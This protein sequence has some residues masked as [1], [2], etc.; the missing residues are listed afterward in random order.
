[1]S[2]GYFPP[3]DRD[4]QIYV[5]HIDR[6]EIMNQFLLDLEAMSKNSDQKVRDVATI[7]GHR[8]DQPLVRGRESGVLG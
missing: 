1:M 2:T 7:V 8:K 6:E 4:Q 5:I 3:T